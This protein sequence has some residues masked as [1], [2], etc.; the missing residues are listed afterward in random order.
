M[1]DELNPKAEAMLARARLAHPMQITVEEYTL[2][3]LVV[4]HAR[5]CDCPLY[6][7]RPSRR[8]RYLKMAA[9]PELLLEVWPDEF[10]RDD[11][12]ESVIRH[13]ARRA[14]LAP[15]N[16]AL[17]IP[18]ALAPLMRQEPPVAD[19]AVSVFPD[20]TGKQMVHDPHCDHPSRKRATTTATAT[21]FLVDSLHTLIPLVLPGFPGEI[22][23]V[24]DSEFEIAPCVRN[25]PTTAPTPVPMATRLAVARKRAYRALVALHSTAQ[26]HDAERARE[27][28]QRLEQRMHMKGERRALISLTVHDLFGH[29]VASSE[30][31]CWVGVREEAQDVPSW[32]A[33]D[34]QDKADR[35]V[36]AALAARDRHRL[37]EERQQE[38]GGTV[39]GRAFAD[40]EETGR[41]A[42]RRA[43]SQALTEVDE[44][45]RKAADAAG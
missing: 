20:A 23:D 29:L 13:L 11:G 38:D 4:I 8:L 42:F 45:R 28:W 2:S 10:L 44:L 7:V 12:Y 34:D 40:A 30:A 39:M 6:P 17:I 9:L 41:R 14:C 15:C 26:T 25:L 33:L 36:K 18:P 21:H 24:A 27:A 19:I 32:D 16:P 3:R 31:T 37:R 22:R 5:A 35:W 1:S 43:V